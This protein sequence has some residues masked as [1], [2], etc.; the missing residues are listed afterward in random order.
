[1]SEHLLARFRQHTIDRAAA[2]NVQLALRDSVVEVVILPGDPAGRKTL[3]GIP[4]IAMG[5]GGTID[6]T[7]PLGALLDSERNRDRMGGRD[8]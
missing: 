7:N 3:R 1:M 6:G 2:R 5:V 4:C 8:L